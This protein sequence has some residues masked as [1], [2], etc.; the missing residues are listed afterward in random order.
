MYKQI[1]NFL[2]IFRFFFKLERKQENGPKTCEGKD[3][4]RTKG[5]RSRKKRRQKEQKDYDRF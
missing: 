1:K 4:E 3:T 5:L 2:Q